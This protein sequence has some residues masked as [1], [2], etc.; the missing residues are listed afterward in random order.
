VSHS[1][2]PAGWLRVT[3]IVIDGPLS[4]FELLAQRSKSE[5]V[6]AKTLRAAAAGGKP[7]GLSMQN[8]NPPTHTAG[9]LSMYGLLITFVGYLLHSGD[10]YRLSASEPTAAH[11]TRDLYGTG[12]MTTACCTRR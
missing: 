11:L 2:R 8:W 6:S 5:K 12:S 7:Q 4:F 3:G 9:L 1:S 10:P